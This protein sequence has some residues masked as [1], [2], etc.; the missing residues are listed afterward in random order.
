MQAPGIAPYS[1]NSD[2]HPLP[3]IT[4]FRQLE[5]VGSHALTDP[6]LP[7]CD[8]RTFG[9]YLSAGIFTSTCHFRLWLATTTAPNRGSAALGRCGRAMLAGCSAG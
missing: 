5:W 7:G 9:P 2:M 1:F 3:K 6:S 8:H 4:N